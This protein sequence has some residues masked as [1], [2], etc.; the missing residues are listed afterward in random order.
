M[1]AATSSISPDAAALGRKLGDVNVVA[2]KL[3]C[4]PRHTYRL[5]DSGK[6]PLPRRLGALVRWDLDEIDAW[7]A[8]GCPACRRGVK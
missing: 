7:I 2:Q 6:M 5:A 3:S 8:A 4:S 1:T